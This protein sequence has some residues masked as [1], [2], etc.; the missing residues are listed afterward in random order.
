MR[1]IIGAG[2]RL[3]IWETSVSKVKMQ[4]KGDET[5][6]EF[7][8]VPQDPHSTV[9]AHTEISPHAIYDG[10]SDMKFGFHG[11]KA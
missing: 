10:P 3:F 7:D 11:S 9:S 1:I 4:V 5:E 8:Q 2:S 6:E